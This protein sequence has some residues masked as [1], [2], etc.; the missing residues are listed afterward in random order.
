MLKAQLYTSSNARWKF[1]LKYCIKAFK[2]G[3]TISLQ[4]WEIRTY[5]SMSRISRIVEIW[6]WMIDI[7]FDSIGPH[8]SDIYENGSKVGAINELF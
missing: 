6:D 1:I 4:I 3:I 8:N 7:T 5:Q 2:H